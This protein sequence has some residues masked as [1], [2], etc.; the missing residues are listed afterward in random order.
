MQSIIVG[1]DF[2]SSSINAAHY[3]VNLGK[4]FRAKIVLFH[5]YVVPICLSDFPVPL[6]EE[7]DIE[8]ELTTRLNQLADDLRSVNYYSGEIVCACRAGSVSETIDHL[9][10]EFQGGLIVVGLKKKHNWL[11]RIGGSVVYRVLDNVSIPVLTIPEH[12]SFRFSK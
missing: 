1:I 8:M 2:H 5:A 4:L 10:H 3:A 11:E 6:L 12:Q 9:I 7:D